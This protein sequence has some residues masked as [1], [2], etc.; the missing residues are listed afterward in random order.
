M[1]IKCKLNV[2]LMLILWK[3][4]MNNVKKE[5]KHEIDIVISK[6]NFQLTTLILKANVE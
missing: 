1:Q 3:F 5:K 4:K 2:D 6:S